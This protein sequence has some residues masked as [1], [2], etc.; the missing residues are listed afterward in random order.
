M[1]WFISTSESSQSITGCPNSPMPNRPGSEVTCSRIPLSLSSLIDGS[2]NPPEGQCTAGPE[3]GVAPSGGP[4]LR[5]R[6]K[7]AHAAPGSTQYEFDSGAPTWFRPPV[8][9]TA[10]HDSHRMFVRPRPTATAS[11][12]GPIDVE[13]MI[14]EDLPIDNSSLAARPLSHLNFVAHPL[15]PKNAVTQVAC[16]IRPHHSASRILR[17][18]WMV[19]VRHP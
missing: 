11:L 6:Q 2:S 19:K 10:T 7:T 1:L 8:C 4:S 3:G 16:R 13:D 14:P 17:F 5:K 12:A 9:T 18:S 15:I